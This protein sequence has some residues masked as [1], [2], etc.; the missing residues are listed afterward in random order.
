MTA[1]VS[2]ERKKSHQKVTETKDWFEPI[3]NSITIA[4]TLTP[5]TIIGLQLSSEGTV[6]KPTCSSIIANTVPQ[7][8]KVQSL[9]TKIVL[10]S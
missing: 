4:M 8:E 3:T 9:K 6:G 10:Q 5:Y 1:C 2:W 7:G